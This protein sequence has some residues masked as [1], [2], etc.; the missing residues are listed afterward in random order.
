MLPRFYFQSTLATVGALTKALYTRADHWP[1]MWNISQD[2]LAIAD[3]DGRL[4]TINPAWTELLGWPEAELLGKSAQWLRHP[5]DQERTRAEIMRLITGRKTVHFENRL[6]AKDGSCHWI[7]WKAALYDG[8]IYATGRDISESA[9]AEEARH[10]LETNRAHVNRVSVMGALAASL[11]HE[12]KQPIATARN[13][14]RAALNFLEMPVPD[15]AEVRE[16]LGGIVSDADRAGEIIDRIRDHI[17]KASPRHERFD[18]NESITE[19]L[20]LARTVISKNGVSLQTRLA[21]GLEPVLAD[22]IQLQQVALN[23][24]LN[25]IEAMASVET[26]GRELLIITERAETGGVLVEVRDSGPGIDPTHWERVFEAF[27]TTKMNGMGMGL[28]IC[29]SII[30]AHGG[31]LW[32]DA[33]EPRG[34]LFQFTLPGADVTL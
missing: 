23:L 14:A 29:R 28:S 10:E 16:A 15:L 6:R 13:N 5:D 17:T 19:V 7:S 1:A 32:A 22:R 21:A 4:L 27:Y 33:N 12:V 20:D 25:A 26:E 2:L 34:A 8:R 30:D 31:R 18:L 24:V 3:S 9:R 11:A